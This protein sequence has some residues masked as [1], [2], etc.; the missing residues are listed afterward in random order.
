MRS[1]KQT[2]F[3]VRIRRG[4][5]S[6]GKDGIVLAKMMPTLTR[7]IRR[8]S[9]LLL[10]VTVKSSLRYLATNSGMELPWYISRQV[11]R[12]CLSGG[13]FYG[14]K[15]FRSLLRYH[16][17]REQ[18]NNGRAVFNSEGKL[19]VFI[20]EKVRECVYVKF[21]IYEKVRDCVYVKCSFRKD[22]KYQAC[23]SLTFIQVSSKQS[24]QQSKTSEQTFSC[25]NQKFQA[26]K[27]SPLHRSVSPP[28]LIFLAT[29]NITRM[30][31]HQQKK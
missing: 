14:L 26:C 22:R 21:S 9:L 23:M 5:R 19:W 13:I 30:L 1:P 29:I 25:H 16:S 12:G 27:V 6:R 10:F 24:L 7:S 31:E 3:I 28:S 17:N 15:F 11:R 4:R 8:S 18:L 2:F 20:H